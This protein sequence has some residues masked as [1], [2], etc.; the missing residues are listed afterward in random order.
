MAVVAAV[1]A[2]GLGTRLRS[3]LP[4]RAKA[5]AEI[6]ASPFLELV[7]QQ[8][9]GE[10]VAKVVLC[11]GY[12]GHQI[13][14]HFG[15]RWGGLELGYSEESE[16]RGTGGALRLAWPLL[17]GSGAVLVLNGDSYYRGPLSPLVECHRQKGASAT[18]LLSRVPDSRRFGR[19]R[20]KRD[21]QVLEFLEKDPAHLAPAWVSAGLYLIEPD[22]FRSI[23]ADRP[24]SLEKEVFPGLIGR[25]L[26]GCRGQGEFLDIGTP[27]SYA[28][29]VDFFAKDPEGRA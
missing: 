6:G 9:A 24:V 4:N 29:A 28:R 2:G 22:V 12:L 7:L 8:L 10:G 23:P 3:V 11:I 17:E 1:L 14:S 18:L 20:I 27:E 13:R 25:G 16:P 19:V 21:G 15:E 26:Y 5:L